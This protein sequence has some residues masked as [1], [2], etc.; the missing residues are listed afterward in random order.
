MYTVIKE[1]KFWL[2]H[3]QCKKCW[4]KQALIIS[5]CQRNI[6]Q[7]AVGTTQNASKIHATFSKSI[8]TKRYTNVVTLG[9]RTVAFCEQSVSGVSSGLMATGASLPP[10]EFS[11]SLRCGKPLQATGPL[12]SNNTST[13]RIVNRKLLESF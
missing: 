9:R 6:H 1:T 12:F 11:S 2:K 7:N 13:N 5:Q 10:V 3:L 8:Q 4:H